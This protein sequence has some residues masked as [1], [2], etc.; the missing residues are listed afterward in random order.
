MIQKRKCIKYKQHNNNIDLGGT[1]G[2]G[3]F[4]RISG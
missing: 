3:H 2:K 1:Y 4:N